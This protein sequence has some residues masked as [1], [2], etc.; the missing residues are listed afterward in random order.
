M[1]NAVAHAGK[2][3]RRVVSA[4]IATAFARGEAD[5]DS[6]RWIESPPNAQ[7]ASTQWRGVADHLRPKSPKL[8]NLMDAA[9]HEVLAHTGF[10]GTNRAK[11]HSTNPIERLDG[12]IK[13]L[14]EKIA[15]A[16]T[17]RATLI[18]KMIEELKQVIYESFTNYGIIRSCLLADEIKNLG[19]KQELLED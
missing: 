1:R 16:D 17:R 12:E 8:A 11:R 9:D 10:P 19:Y 13:I 6:I 7:A 5:Q 15:T 3:G 18:G 14:N 2:S 4:F